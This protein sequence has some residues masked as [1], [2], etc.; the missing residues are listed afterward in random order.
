MMEPIRAISDSLPF[1]S[2]VLA[3]LWL[4]LSRAA[5]SPVLTWDA[6][7]PDVKNR[8]RQIGEEYRAYLSRN[9]TD[10]EVVEQLQE[11][12]RHHRFRN[13]EEAAA[14]KEPAAPGDKFFHL[15]ND[16]NGALIMAGRAPVTSGFNLVVAHT[17]AP[18][19][20]VTP[21]PL[22]SENDM[23]MLSVTKQQVSKEYQWLSRPLAIHGTV[24][25]PAGTK[26][27]TVGED[28]DGFV[29]VIPD[30][31][32]AAYTPFTESEGRS[33]AKRGALKVMAGS[34][35]I[36]DKSLSYT[37]QMQVLKF[38]YDKYGMTENDFLTASLQVVP[39]GPA[40]E[41]GEGRHL[42]GGY[43]HDGRAGCFAASYA[44][45]TAAKAPRWAVCLFVDQLPVMGQNTHQRL[46]DQLAF[47]T[48][49]IADLTGQPYTDTQLR[50][51]LRSSRG[52]VAEVTNG[53][54]PLFEQINEMGNA[55][56]LGSGAVVM[57]YLGM[58]GKYYT[59][60]AT[61]EYM[62]A[63]RR[64]CTEAGIIWQQA[65][66]GKVDEGGGV[67]LSRYVSELG[68][69]VV[70]VALPVL[71]MHSPFAI[72]SKLDIHEIYRFYRAFLELE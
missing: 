60:E 4:V 7:E 3:L 13:L 27:V 58:G 54:N 49:K 65:E 14:K 51:V 28:D 72:C 57:K 59:N 48:E 6:L 2:A 30:L 9:K 71:S 69:D 5:E 43:G 12:A 53:V 67:S 62:A 26:R 17:D 32:R 34:V 45:R 19:L 52:V 61:P 20:L 29:L 10:R 35:P 41:V 25:T 21:R 1:R 24:I 18:H 31:A 66:F 64:L 44:L 47:L 33:I 68:M 22:V 40:R 39:A 56:F 63:I 23:L 37:V 15:F 70:D 16:K 46:W 11:D 36:D 38:F 42:I 50:A 8:I 55:A